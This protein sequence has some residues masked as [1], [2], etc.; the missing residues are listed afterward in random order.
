VVFICVGTLAVLGSTLFAVR[1]VTVTFANY[2]SFYTDEDGNLLDE[3]AVSASL[4]ASVLPV[5]M[6]R[7]NLFGISDAKVREAMETADTRVRV[8][9]IERKFPNSVEITV[10]ERYPVYRLQMADNMTAVICGR[11]RVL[12]ILD[13]NGLERLRAI[14]LDIGA[15]DLIKIPD[16]I[17][18]E[19]VLAEL[20]VGEFLTESVTEAGKPYIDI[21]KEIVPHF[22]RYQT[23]EDTICHVFDE[24]EFDGVP[25]SLRLVM[26]SRSNPG[27]LLPNKFTFYV[28]G[29]ES[30]RLTDMLTKA[31][32]AVGHNPDK[33][34]TYRVMLI[35]DLVGTLLEEFSTEG[36]V[37]RFSPD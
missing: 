2:L 35:D 28:L 21:L 32:M 7:N 23:F 20:K 36:I 17:G 27:A 24:I 22:A 8:T 10:R 14:S 3:E 25:G 6:N 30:P 34:G 37:I 19:I 31:W 13:V 4:R 5:T 12:D 29:A 33:P 26:K 18:E 15:W 11:L 9:N 1:T 16:E